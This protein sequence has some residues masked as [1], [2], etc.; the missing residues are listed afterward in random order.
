VTPPPEALREQ[1][2]T[3]WSARRLAAWLRREKKI[4]VNHDSI[5]RLWR[6][7]CLQPHRVEAGI[8]VPASAAHRVGRWLWISS[9]VSATYSA[10][11]RGELWFASSDAIDPH[12]SRAS[13]GSGTAKALSRNEMSV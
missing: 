6:R 13:G 2:I 8:W 3:H 11:V 12:C 7:F 4:K 5:T 9:L 10:P 1:G